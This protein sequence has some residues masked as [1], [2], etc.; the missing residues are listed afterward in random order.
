MTRQ[1][2]LKEWPTIHDGMPLI[3]NSDAAIRYAKVA[4]ENNDACNSLLRLRD[5]LEKQYY[6]LIPFG[7]EMI[8]SLASVV[9]SHQFSKDAMREIVRLR[10]TRPSPIPPH[11]LICDLCPFCKYSLD[12]HTDLGDCPDP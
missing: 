2:T 9:F 5:S 4:F 7:D 11:N 3:K 12:S 10:H 8:K 6:R 1:E